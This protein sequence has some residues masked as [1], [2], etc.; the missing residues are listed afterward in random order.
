MPPRTFVILANR[1]FPSPRRPAADLAAPNGR[2]WAQPLGLFIDNDFVPSS[3][4]R[5]LTTTNPST[6]DDIFSVYA[7]TPDDVDTA[8]AAARATFGH[9]SWRRISGI[10]RGSPMMKL[11]D[12]V[13]AHLETLATI[14]TLDS[15]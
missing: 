14:E 5:T 11:A 13:D 3:N 15:G 8:V 1:P 2:T 12:L 9:P 6:E 7:A 10:D 4:R